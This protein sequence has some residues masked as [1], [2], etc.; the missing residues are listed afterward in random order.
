MRG[1]AP[2]PTSFF[3]LTQKTKQKSSRLR[4]KIG[5]ANSKIF[6]NTGTDCKSA[7]AVFTLTT[8]VSYLPGALNTLGLGSSLVSVK[9]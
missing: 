5:I 6:G 7:P 3:G 1:F 8:S 9:I 4:S 2:S